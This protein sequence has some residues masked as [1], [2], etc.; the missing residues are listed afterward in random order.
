VDPHIWPL[1]GIVVI[2]GIPA[3]VSTL[4]FP[5]VRA[6]FVRRM[7]GQGAEDDARLVAL[8]LQVDALQRELEVVTQALQRPGAPTSLPPLASP[9]PDRSLRS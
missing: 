4:F 6:A 1:L 3:A 7:G 5:S 8:Q 2:V 9:P